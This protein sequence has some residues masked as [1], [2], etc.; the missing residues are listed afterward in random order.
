M[1]LSDQV[2]D[3][4]LETFIKAIADKLFNGI[5]TAYNKGERRR[6]IW[7]LV[8]NAKDVD[9]KE[10]LGPVKI[11]V[12]CR[13]HELVFEHNAD[14][15]DIKSLIGLV[16]Q[17]S[18]KGSQANTETTGKF[19][20]GFITTHMLSK[21][22]HIDSILEYGTDAKRFHLTLDRNAE[23]PEELIDKVKESFKQTE[24]LSNDDLYPPLTSK[25]RETI[26]GE[27]NT[28]FVYELSSGTIR[29]AL[30]GIHDLL[31]NSAF[32]LL[33]NKRIGEIEI[34]NEIDHSHYRIFREEAHPLRGNILLFKALIENKKTGDIKKSDLAYLPGKDGLT[35]AV[36]VSIGSDGVINEVIGLKKKVPVLFKDF[37]L[38][39]T[40][41]WMFDFVCNGVFFEPTDPRDGLYLHISG[42]EEKPGLKVER[43]RELIEKL[44]DEALSLV[45]LLS[46]PA[47]PP[48]GLYR[49]MRSG[50]PLQEDQVDVKDFLLKLQTTFR[51]DARLLPIVN[52]SEGLK[53][54]I[55]CRF[56]IF[57]PSIASSDKDYLA[58][59]HLCVAPFGKAIPIETEFLQWLD[60]IQAESH[61]WNANAALNLEELLKFIENSGKID[62]LGFNEVNDAALWLNQVY[63]FLTKN[64]QIHLYDRFKIV[65]NQDRH[66][67][68][69]AFIEREQEGGIPELLKDAGAAF[70]KPYR[71]TLI[72]PGLNCDAVK[73]DRS[74]KEISL[75]LN[76]VIGQSN[77]HPEKDPDEK[78]IAAAR[79]CHVVTGGQ[80]ADD[81]RLAITRHLS[82]IIAVGAE[83]P[84]NAPQLRG[85]DFKFRSA[86]RAVVKYCLGKV[87]LAGSINNLLSLLNLEKKEDSEF[88]LQ[89]LVRLIEDH[90]E[91][92]E[93]STEYG[94]Y[95]DQSSNFHL[96]KE[97]AVDVD[98][99]D[100][101]LKDMHNRLFPSKNIR[102]TLLL[103]DFQT[104]AVEK[105]CYQSTISGEI[106]I[107]LDTRYLHNDAG[108]AMGVIDWL[109]SHL[110][111]EQEFPRLK[112]NKPHIV[113]KSLP[114]GKREPI[115]NLIKMD[116]DIGALTMIVES[117]HFDAISAAV[118]AGINITQL[119]R[120]QQAV[121]G[122]ENLQ[123]IVDAHMEEQAN[124]AFLRHL[125]SHVEQKFRNAFEGYAQ[126]LKVEREGFDWGQD[127]AITFS[128]GTHYFV[129]VKSYA[130]DKQKVHMSKRQGK[131]AV[132][133][134]S[135]Y[136][137]CVLGRT[138]NLKDV[139]EMYFKENARFIMDIG[140]RLRNR[141]DAAI[142]IEALIDEE[143][144]GEDEGID[145][146][147][148]NFK[149]KIGK[150]V[151]LGD[152]AA[153]FDLF[154][155]NLL[156][157]AKKIQS[158]SI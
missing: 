133:N 110:E 99:M 59:Y 34:I 80:R 113:F 21:V 97:L 69:A 38:V 8:Q 88:W 132:E 14:P 136:A 36:P 19:G 30:E 124:L 6:W 16:Q 86:L 89:R 26:L 83:T 126:V 117:E 71:S 149:Y 51:T 84:V 73:K 55:E 74:L 129:E 122:I 130:A 40:E 28:R 70:G 15:F 158:V 156:E 115:F 27:F 101:F 91:L 63:S 37:P 67:C 142:R 152:E 49:L 57:D 148:K 68:F 45:K 25:E 120:I 116:A 33:F 46:D 140:I 29:S 62:N 139:T 92:K 131:T 157:R 20:T 60:I 79:L 39:G 54:I 112:T 23:T 128:D 123:E 13:A 114:P 43:N 147:N 58:F 4:Q 75:E 1:S 146:D 119:T 125:G 93:F 137:L 111:Y 138:E 3:A 96:A 141:V 81:T 82:R 108:M 143:A 105:I 42:D 94:I 11:R 44:F 103:Q 153:T 107:E 12:I 127:F 145:F 144:A 106:D 10:N 22:V 77:I 47:T 135:N 151:W 41:N 109:D 66:F 5:Q 65:P 104:A 121:G 150:R 7:E 155:N 53:P 35:L 56:P 118:E 85:E 52:T 134:P 87:Q 9:I 18:S 72:F 100:D 48:L 98:C 64:D 50:L 95:P 31:S 32:V 78:L 24:Q 2:K 17:T 76:E 90:G 154:V 61:T 102:S